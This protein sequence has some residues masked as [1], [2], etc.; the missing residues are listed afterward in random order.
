MIK[1]GLHVIPPACGDS[2]SAPRVLPSGVSFSGVH[3]PYFNSPWPPLASPADQEVFKNTIALPADAFLGECL[4][5]PRR[6]GC[7]EMQTHMTSPAC[8]VFSAIGFFSLL[9]AREDLASPV[10]SSVD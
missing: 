5:S 7:G 2:V 4:P 6:E 1:S 10:R 3:Q 8:L 9:Y